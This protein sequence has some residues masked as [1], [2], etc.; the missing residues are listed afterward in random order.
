MYNCLTRSIEPELVAACRRYGLSIVIYNPLAG[1]LLSGKY[2]TAAVPLEGRF[3]DASG[4]GPSYRQRYFK[5]SSFEALSIIEPVLEKHG[6]TLIET[7]LRWIL[8]HSSL[9][10]KDGNDGIIIG[11]GNYR[12]FEENLK[13]LG[14]GPLPQEVL[15]ALDKAWI[16]KKADA[17]NYW[18]LD[19]AYSYDTKKVLFEV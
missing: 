11:V 9:Q 2:K 8:H 18:H 16:V 14:K 4:F 6:L 17:P 12:Q 19:L 7:A 1:G 10:M 15:E 13:D 5:D 3:S